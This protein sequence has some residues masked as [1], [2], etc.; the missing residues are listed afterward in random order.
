MDTF[1]RCPTCNFKVRLKKTRWER[2]KLVVA[3]P[4][5]FFYGDHYP[6]GNSYQPKHCIVSSQ[7]YVVATP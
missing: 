4:G 3:T 1:V 6:G 2:N 7:E 5:Q